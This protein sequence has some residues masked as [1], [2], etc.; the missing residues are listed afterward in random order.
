M[1][2]TH[3]ARRL[4]AGALA[5][6]LT[7]SLG[8]PIAAADVFHLTGQAHP[9]FDVTVAING[10]TVRTV[11]PSP[12]RV[13]IFLTQLDEGLVRTGE[14]SFEVSFERRPAEGRADPPVP[15]FVVRVKRQTDPADAGTATG[16]VEVRG[17]E[18]PFD[19]ASGSGR[20]TT[21]FT[22]AP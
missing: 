1:H 21:T 20:L 14:N 8:A 13:K 12:D 17:P 3:A 18:R 22:V 6:A 9:R 15:S 5:L 16:V 4:A 2:H 7:W 11:E 19:A 10:T